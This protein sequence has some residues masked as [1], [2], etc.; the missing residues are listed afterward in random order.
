MKNSDSITQNHGYG[1]PSLIILF[2]VALTVFLAKQGEVDT[3]PDNFT[4]SW[5]ELNSLLIPRRALAAV[6]SNG[7]IY[8]IGGIDKFG[9]YVKEVEF[10]KILSDGRLSTWQLTSSLQLGRFYLAAATSNGYI[11]AMG[12]GTGPTGSENRPTAIVE[13]AKI[14]D[15]GELGPWQFDKQMTTPRRG[16]KVVSYNN[17]LFAL[18]GYNGS[19]LKSVERSQVSSLGMLSNWVLSPEE[20]QIDRYIH[21]A[22]L[23]GNTIY[24]L[25]GH[26]RGKN[27][28]SYGDVETVKV[29]PDGALSPWKVEKS[30][31]RLPRFI[32]SAVALNG[33]VYLLA[34]HNGGLRIREVEFSRKDQSG[35][36]KNW[37]FTSALKYERSATAVVSHSI[38]TNSADPDSKKNRHYIYV[39]GGMG[40]MGPLNKVEMA[41]QFPNGQLG[42]LLSLSLPQPKVHKILLNQQ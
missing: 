18:G 9:Q 6:S 11:Y 41:M 38:I 28:M 23:Q 42:G 31:L 37:E 15:N 10:A 27:K 29:N 13:K 17:S 8:S 39:I 3:L 1:F 32:A 19:F 30:T 16:L 14:L 24:L 5:T 2:L 25:G 4:G 12:G 20:A 33:Y 22:A 40:K 26:V 35:K 7:Y 21:S 34:G 36:L